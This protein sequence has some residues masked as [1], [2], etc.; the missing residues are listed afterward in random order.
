MEARWG[1]IPDM[2]GTL[3]LRECMPCDHASRLAM[4]AGCIDS[5]EAKRVGLISEVSDQP[6]ET[7]QALAR[8]LA[9]RS[10]DT[11]REIKAFYRKLWAG[12]E[13][14]I[15]AKETLGQIKILMSKHQRKMARQSQ[16]YI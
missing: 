16:D 15:L 2:G 3:G 9:T 6:L 5:I 7:A 14:W 4:T 12:N 11:N 8:N 10:P 13:R 1:L